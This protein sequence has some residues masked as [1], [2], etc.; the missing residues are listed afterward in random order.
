LCIIYSNGNTA[1]LEVA[2][3]DMP[4]QLLQLANEDS[5]SDCSD[6]ESNEENSSEKRSDG[7]QV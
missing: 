7:Y 2:Q 3:H 6:N 4:K 1:K 5:K